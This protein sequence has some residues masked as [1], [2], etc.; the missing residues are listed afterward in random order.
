MDLSCGLCHNGLGI[1][2]VSYKSFVCCNS[3]SRVTLFQVHSGVE[4]PVSQHNQTNMLQVAI[5][6]LSEGVEGGQLVQ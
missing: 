2:Q 5:V 3:D 4:Q 6:G 1:R